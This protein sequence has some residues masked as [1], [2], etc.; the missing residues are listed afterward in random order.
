MR[1]LSLDQM[2]RDARSVADQLGAQTTEALIRAVSGARRVSNEGVAAATA[3]AEALG[4]Q[5]EQAGQEIAQGAQALA[6]PGASAR[7]AWRAGRF[8]G[9]IEGALRLARFGVR[10][11]WKRRQRGR[12][13]EGRRSVTW[14]RPLAQ[15]GPAVVA[16]G[17]LIAQIWTRR[18]R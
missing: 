1:P 3:G 5:I 11:W 4:G 16:S 15:W 10:F 13:E 18:R 14:L 7:T 12:G 8:V 17:W 6:L 2:T 9:R